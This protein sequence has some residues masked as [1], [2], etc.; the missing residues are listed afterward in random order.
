MRKEIRLI[1]IFY[2][3]LQNYCVFVVESDLLSTK[4]SNHKLNTVT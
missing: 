2:L 4:K 3:S 1:H